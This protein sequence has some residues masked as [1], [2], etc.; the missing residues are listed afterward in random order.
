SG[1]SLPYPWCLIKAAVT[2][3]GQSPEATMV[4]RA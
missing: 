2:R 1:T 4:V 3:H